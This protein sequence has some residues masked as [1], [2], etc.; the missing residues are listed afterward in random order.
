MNDATAFLQGE[1]IAPDA[2]QISKAQHLVQ[3]LCS[4]QM[5]WAHLVECRRHYHQVQNEGA[6]S[7]VMVAESIVLDVDVELPQR[8]INDIRSVERI[9][10]LFGANDTNFPEAFALR[11]DFPL[12]PHVNL[13]SFDY[14]RSLCLSDRLYSEIK[15]SWTAPAFIENIRSWLSL[16]AT[17]TLHAADQPLEPLIIGV[18]P[19][20]I[21]PSDLLSHLNE[22]ELEKLIIRR[23]E[24]GDEKLTLIAKRAAEM[25]ALGDGQQDKQFVVTVV[26]A[27]PQTHGII[28]H[29]PENL[30]ELHGLLEKAGVDLLSVLRSRLRNWQEDRSLWNA[31]LIIITV[32]PKTRRASGL[33][34]AMELRAFLC[35]KAQIEDDSINNSPVASKR[36]DGFLNIL[37]VGEKIGVWKVSGGVPGALIPID[38]EKQ[39]EDVAVTLLNPCFALSRE[40]AASLNGQPQRAAKRIVAVGMGALGSQIFIN[41]IRSA[42]GEWTLIDN[43]FLLPH[44]L[45]RHALFGAVVG[46]SKVEP[47][48]YFANTT[49]DGQPIATAIVADIL[50]PGDAAHSVNENL[51]AA[52]AIC[53]FSA[54]VAVARH[55]AQDISSRARRISAFLNPTGTDLVVLAEDAQRLTNL[56]SLEMQFYRWL[57]HEPDLREHLQPSAER[58]RY[59]QSCR[60]LSSSIPQEHVALHAASASRALR[61]ALA[62]E[63]ATIAL[64]RINDGDGS[65]ENWKINPAPAVEW[66]LYEWTLCADAYLLDK[67]RQARAEKLPRETGGVLLGSYDMQRQIIYVVDTL[68][69]PPDSDEQPKSYIRGCEGLREQVA[70]VEKITTGNLRYIGEWHSHPRGYDCTP[71]SYD[72]NLFK[73]LV[74]QISVDGVPPVKLIVAEDSCAWIVN[75]MPE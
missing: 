14:P 36:V 32:L 15:L 40:S 68:L 59:A 11:E 38:Y 7:Q 72:R 58:I 50:H 22:D 66:Q 37:N 51:D 20:L 33:I 8:L 17:G 18:A 25:R 45:S 19:P 39:G 55:L 41:L 62:D 35:A 60:D 70:E 24:S 44:N 34:E 13:R 74:E 71:S 65:L 6:D 9:Q 30:F 10:V 21:L 1:K 61:R 42:Y 2:L 31:A 56:T 46:S 16:T 73:W 28:R 3:T 27:T 47:L 48:A 75:D 69:S 23:T 57:T 67:V 64:W 29:Q 49:I 12:V 54:S 63:S 43:D 53:D 52:D 4:A 26:E 5:N